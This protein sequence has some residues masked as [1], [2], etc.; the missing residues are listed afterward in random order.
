[1]SN[2]IFN[3]QRTFQIWEYTAG[4]KQLLLR[5]TKAEG[6]PTRID[7]LFKVVRAINLLTV[8]DGLTISEAAEGQQVG[9]RLPSDSLI[10]YEQK[11]FVVRSSN[12]E[13]YVVAGVMA[14]HEDEGEYYDP[15][16]FQLKPN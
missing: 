2:E 14:W 16:H 9:P 12:F 10:L 4:H 13:G 7:V 11:V 3:R 8:M 1:M 15:S 5:S 6:L